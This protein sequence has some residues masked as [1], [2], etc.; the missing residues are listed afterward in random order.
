MNLEDYNLHAK[1]NP[2]ENKFYIC[3]YDTFINE[4]TKWEWAANGVNKYRPDYPKLKRIPLINQ[5]CCYE[6]LEFFIKWEIEIDFYTNN[7]YYYLELL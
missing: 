6:G 3:W 2:I 7:H 5:V 1:F 4:Y